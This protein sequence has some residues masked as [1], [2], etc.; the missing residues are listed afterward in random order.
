MVMR[1]S[2]CLCAAAE[3]HT[4]G[5]ICCSDADAMTDWKAVED[6]LLAQVYCMNFVV[7]CRGRRVNSHQCCISV[8]FCQALS[9]LK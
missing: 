3:A 2:Y 1:G 9:N 6:N 7:S 8:S 5:S 4:A